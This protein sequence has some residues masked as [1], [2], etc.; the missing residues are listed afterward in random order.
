[1]L[2]RFSKKEEK[3]KLSIRLPAVSDNVYEVARKKS[4]LATMVSQFLVQPRQ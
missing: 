1:M 2:L 4:K 3:S